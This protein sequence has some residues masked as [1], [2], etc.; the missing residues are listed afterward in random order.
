MKVRL[1]RLRA[2]LGPSRL[3]SLLDLFATELDHRPGQLCDHLLAGR[4]DQAKSEAHSLKGAS[5][6]V[7]ASELGMAT[8]AIEQ[9]TAADDIKVNARLIDQLEK[10]AAAARAALGRRASDSQRASAINT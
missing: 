6:S 7:G 3:Q 8:L 5:M 2:A 9:L 4:L 10:A 1:D